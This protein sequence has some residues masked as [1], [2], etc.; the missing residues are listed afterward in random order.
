MVLLSAPAYVS[1]AQQLLAQEAA[2]RKPL[3][4]VPT[5]PLDACAP[6]L[7]NAAAIRD[8]VALVVRGKCAFTLKVAAVAAAGASA[9]IVLNNDER[10]QLL[11]KFEDTPPIPV[12][13]LQQTA[14]GEAL[15]QAASSAGGVLLLAV[16]NVGSVN[17]SSIIVTPSPFSS[18]GP[19]SMAA[20]WFV[21][22]SDRMV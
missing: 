3:Q 1:D 6:A 11:M 4:V 8:K 2:L 20:G 19:V 22:V 15:L 17:T 7:A 5:Q 16:K 13:G 21:S 10:S 12:W 18:W 9:V 14:L